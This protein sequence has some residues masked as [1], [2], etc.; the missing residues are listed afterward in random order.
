MKIL[1]WHLDLKFK[2]CSHIANINMKISKPLSF[3]HRFRWFPLHV[4][5]SL[6]FSFINSHI[7]FSSLIFLSI[8]KT[9]INSIKCKYKKALKLLNLGDCDLSHDFE[10]IIYYSN[11]NFL[12]QIL[13]HHT[14]SYLY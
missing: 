6:F 9:G 1:G 5:K 12:H 4:R 14:L 13:V 11:C 2:F 7:D 10:E 8:N 3:L